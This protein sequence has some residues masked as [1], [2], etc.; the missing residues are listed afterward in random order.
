[1]TQKFGQGFEGLE[2]RTLLAANVTAS[3]IGDTLVVTGDST[4]NDIS[5]HGTGVSGA[6]EVS[7]AGLGQTL[8][9]N[10]GTSLDATDAS[11]TGVK[12]IVIRGNDGDDT[13]D[14]YDVNIQGSLTENGGLGSDVLQLQ[15]IAFDTFVG[16]GVVLNGGG[17]ANDGAEVDTQVGSLNNLTIGGGLCMLNTGGSRGLLVDAEGSGDISVGS[18]IVMNEFSGLGG[19]GSAEIIS[20]G[21]GYVSVGCSVIMNGGAGND[22]LGLIGEA[23]GVSSGTGISV[24]AGVTISG[25]WGDDDEFIDANGAGTLAGPISDNINIGGSVVMLGG[26]GDDTLSVNGDLAG[27]NIHGA[28]GLYGGLGNDTIK[29]AASGLGAGSVN[30]GFGLVADGSDGND[31]IGIN[32]ATIG[33]SALVAGGAGDDEI[34]LDGNSVSGNFWAFGQLGNDTICFDNNTVGFNAGVFGGLGDNSAYINGNTVGG[35]LFV[36]GIQHQLN[37][38]PF[39][40]LATT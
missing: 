18:S 5:V 1:M 8:A 28:A 36:S 38:C 2:E 10:G 26:V 24:G 23:G 29:V 40:V 37:S 22:Q 20:G 3:L 6:V 30:V 4:A 11:F 34:D 33:G 15:S 31:F 9:V 14:V 21:L 13:I 25:G 12:N 32:G 27:V 17:G 39:D 7:I 35:F 19:S 16:G